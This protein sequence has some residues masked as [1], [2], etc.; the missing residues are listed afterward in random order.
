M[1]SLLVLVLLVGCGERRASMKVAFGGAVSAGTG[2]LLLHSLDGDDEAPA[3]LIALG[4]LMFL[5]GSL[6]TVVW[7][8]D[9]IAAGDPDS[10]PPVVV[11]APMARP[12]RVLARKLL[13]DAAAAARRDDCEAVRTADVSVRDLDAEFHALV[14]VRDA[15]IARCL[16]VR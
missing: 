3:N 8:I 15:A 1:R 10:A 14:F 6:V 7:G 16:A 4:A 11:A 9:A 5:G 13:I 12:A 2:A